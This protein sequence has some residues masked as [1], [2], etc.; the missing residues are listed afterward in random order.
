MGNDKSNPND[1]D[2]WGSPTKGEVECFY[3]GAT[4]NIENS[5]APIDYMATYCSRECYI[6]DMQYLRTEGEPT[7]SDNSGKNLDD[8]NYEIRHI[9]D[10]KLK[11]KKEG[12]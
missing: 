8:S 5:S 9:G 12:A 3:C 2:I 1:L 7:A 11:V 4:Y 10:F 6:K